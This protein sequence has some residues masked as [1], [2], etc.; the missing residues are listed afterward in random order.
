MIQS[1]RPTHQV[2]EHREGG[3]GEPPCDDHTQAAQLL[4]TSAR[5]SFSR[6]NSPDDRGHLGRDLRASSRSRIRGERPRNAALKVFSGRNPRYLA[7]V[8]RWFL[9]SG[10]FSFPFAPLEPLLFILSLDLTSARQRRK[11]K[12]VLI[13][14]AA[15]GSRFPFSLFPSR[16][17][18]CPLLRLLPAEFDF[19]SPRCALVY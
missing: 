9:H 8:L 13:F 4:A 12:P 15:N 1:S 5:C 11:S 18:R 17:Q 6:P 19:G 3:P 16:C 7:D 14:W 2:A 10:L